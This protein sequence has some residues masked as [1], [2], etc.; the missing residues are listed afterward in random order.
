MRSVAVNLDICNFLLVRVV[1]R[2]IRE[3]C[4]EL[5]QIKYKKFHYDKHLATVFVVLL[6]PVSS[7]LKYNKKFS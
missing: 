3:E 2:S 5:V 1:T 7:Q 6:S 4:S